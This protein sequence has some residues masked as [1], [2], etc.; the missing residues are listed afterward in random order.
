MGLTGGIGAGKSAVAARLV[1]HGAVLIDADRLA[2][3]VV[4]PGTGGLA[5]IVAAFG[6]G[7]LGPDGALDRAAM[8]ARVF[9]DEPARRRLE[10]IIHPRVRSRTTRLTADAPTDAVV[11]NDVPLLVETGLAPTYHLVIVVDAASATR[12][13]RLVARRGMSPDEATGRIRAQATDEQRRAAA[14]VLLGNDGTLRRLAERVDALWR[15]R[16]VPFEEN[17]RA[18]RAAPTGTDPGGTDP[19]GDGLRAYD[20]L[21]ARI[22]H[23]AGPLL[24]SVRPAA[25]GVIEAAVAPDAD[26][27]RVSAALLHAGFPRLPDA[28]AA[29]FTDGAGGD[30][31]VHG[32]ADPGRP[33]TVYLRPAVPG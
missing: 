23:A 22:G 15:E 10:A 21:A 28:V 8:A 4:A 9:G 26:L 5:E 32:N 31:I 33:A 11:V 6:A 19:G 25:Q 30:V 13:E 18:G 2:R 14:D 27:D 3:E 20:R 1:D 7:I 17:L 16:L 29:G 12:V 24:R